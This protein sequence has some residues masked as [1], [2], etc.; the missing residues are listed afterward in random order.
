MMEVFQVLDNNPL[1][2]HSHVK[3]ALDSMGWE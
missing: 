2:G 3:M 1:L